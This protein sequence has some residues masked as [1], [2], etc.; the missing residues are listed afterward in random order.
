MSDKNSHLG[1]FEHLLLLALMQLGGKSHGTLIRHNLKD[2]V[3]RDASIGA[4]YATLERMEKKGYVTSSVGE[5]TAERGGR[6]K[7]Y[8]EVTA[9]GKKL[10]KQTKKNLEVMWQGVQLW[11]NL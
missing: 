1:E 10:L 8:F 4:L 3:N 11:Q 9:E 5:P 2:L 7:R 6:A